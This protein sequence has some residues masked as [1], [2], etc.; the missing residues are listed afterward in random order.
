MSVDA[1]TVKALRD[2]TGAGMMDCKEALKQ[3]DGDIE[4]ALVFLREKGIASASKKSGRATK[5]GKVISY[6]HPG[7]KLGVMVEIN[8]ETDFVA[9]GAEFTAFARDIAMHIAAAGPKYLSPDEVPEEVLESERSIFRTQAQNE[10]KP[11]KII[12]KIIEGRIN[13]FYA[14][15]CL[16]EQAYVKDDKVKIK[17]YVKSGIAQFGEN[18]GIARF[19]RFKIG[20]SE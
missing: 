17:D 20:E 11:E 14:E 5:E 4:K 15:V 13:K 2:K 19:A 16:L 3:T 1:K 12:E 18:I 7:D 9:K 8:C 10:N 6:I